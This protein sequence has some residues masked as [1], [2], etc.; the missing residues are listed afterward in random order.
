MNTNT[1]LLKLKRWITPFK[2]VLALYMTFH[3]HTEKSFVRVYVRGFV[4]KM[5]RMYTL[6]KYMPEFVLKNI[7]KIYKRIWYRLWYLLSQSNAK[8]QNT[9]VQIHELHIAQNIGPY[10]DVRMSWNNFFFVAFLPFY[11]FSVGSAD[12]QVTEFYK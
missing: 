3:Y 2:N 11:K 4:I 6:C 9:I 5:F 7:F 1:H 8:Y 10:S 12:F